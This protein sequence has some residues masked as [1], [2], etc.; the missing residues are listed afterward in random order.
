MRRFVLSLLV[1]VSLSGVAFAQNASPQAPAP[2]VAPLTEV[3]QLKLERAAL[4]GQ[5][6]AAAKEVAQWRQLFANASQALGGF[7]SKAA[8][9]QAKQAGAAV[10]QEL[11]AARPGFSFD[12]Q[13]GTFKP[14]Q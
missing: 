7:E 6:A 4:I 2:A 10:I 9:D 13:T 3:E 8:E 14:K 5:L 11:E 1:L 12:V